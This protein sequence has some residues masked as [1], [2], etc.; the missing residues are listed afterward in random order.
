M[1]KAGRYNGQN[2]VF[3]L[4][5]IKM[6]TTVQKI[7]TKKKMHSLAISV[8]IV[9]TFLDLTQSKFTSN[10]KPIWLKVFQLN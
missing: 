8:S 7:T 9:L 2:V 3:Q 10:Q 4:A 6:K 5:I 1:R